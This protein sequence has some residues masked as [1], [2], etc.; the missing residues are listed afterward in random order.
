MIASEKKTHYGLSD[1][2]QFIFKKRFKVNKKLIFSSKKLRN[3]GN[4]IYDY[5]HSFFGEDFKS[6]ALY[7]FII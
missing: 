4:C 5:V 1:Y 3:S 6:K 2:K 7:W